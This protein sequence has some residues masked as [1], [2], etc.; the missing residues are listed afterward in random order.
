MIED[1]K[2][3]IKLNE[4]IK[5]NKPAAMV[6][7][8]TSDGSTPRGVGSNMLVDEDGNLLEGTIGGGI[9]EERAKKDAAKYIRKKESILINYNLNRNVKDSNTLPMTCGGNVSLFIKVYSPQEKLIIAGAGHISEKISKI[10]KI[11][12]YSITVMD[13]RKER[14]SPEIFPEV[15]NLMPGSIVE[16]LNRI[17]IDKNT[18]VIIVTHGHKYDQEALEAVLRSDARYIDMIGSANKIRVCFKNLLEKGYTKDE[19]SKVYTPIG[20]DLGGE[21]PEEIALSVVAEIQAVKYGK[22][23][24]NLSNGISKFD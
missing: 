5:K 22:D 24:P 2:V 10:A 1:R 9:L 7:I 4:C 23:V 12:G 6:T 3:L 11:L 16:N 15:E 18:F 8:I 19:L 17:S 21:T 13:D 20:I 14:L